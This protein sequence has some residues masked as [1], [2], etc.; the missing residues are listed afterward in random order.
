MIVATLASEARLK[1][2]D[3]LALREAVDAAVVVVLGDLRVL[4]AFIH[5]IGHISADDGRTS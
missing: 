3:I 1:L 5:H 2:V 4:A